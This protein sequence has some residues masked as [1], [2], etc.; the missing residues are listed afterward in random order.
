MPFNMDCSL[1][2]STC[3]AL[4]H[5]LHCA[6]SDMLSQYQKLLRSTAL[7]QDTF[8]VLHKAIYPW[9]SVKVTPCRTHMLRDLPRSISVQINTAYNRSL[10]HPTGRCYSFSKVTN[11]DETDQFYLPLLTYS[12]CNTAQCLMYK[13]GPRFLHRKR[14]TL[15]LH[16]SH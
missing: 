16:P 4:L 2:I 5:G 13:I 8:F 10:G 9:S 15:A 11:M 14:H 6:L 3:C 1:C 12:A 7:L